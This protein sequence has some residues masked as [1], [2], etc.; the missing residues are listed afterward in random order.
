[1]WTAQ[2]VNGAYA[3]ADMKFVVLPAPNATNAGLH[4]MVAEGNHAFNL[5]AAQY[6]IPNTQECEHKTGWQTITPTMDKCFKLVF[7]QNAWQTLFYIDS[8]AHDAVAFFAQH[9]P[10]EFEATAHYLKDNV[11]TDVEPMAELPVPAPAAPAPTPAPTTE[12]DKPWGA[13]ILSAVLVNLVTL[14]GVI[15]VIPCSKRLL[16]TYFDQFIGIVSGFA[17]GAILACAFFLLLFEATHLIA[18]YWT[19]PEYEEVDVTW[20]WGTMILAGFVLPGFVDAG[21]SLVVRKKPAAAPPASGEGDNAENAEKGEKAELASTNSKARVIAGVLI[22]DFFHNLCDGFFLGAGFKG[23]GNSFGWGIALSTILHELPQE[24]ADYTILTGPLGGMGPIMALT[25]NFLSG[26]SV[27]IGAIMIVATDVSD[28]VTG[29]LLA[30]GGGVYIHIAATEC[31]PRIYN[32]KLSVPVRVACIASF[33]LG[34]VLIG[35]IL[36]DHE[37]C[38][39][40]A[41]PAAPGAAPAPSG[42]HH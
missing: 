34:C 12:K 14:I 4:H 2:K 10:T 41:P 1:M 20:R 31:M 38:V 35:L 25:T 37:H 32:E 5:A 42:H 28:H 6:F 11:G 29:L 17:A 26:L 21:A 3:D 9:V 15:L 8:T 39:P 27:L 23:C 33:I 7:A 36:L 13:T 19:A 22:G 18:T 40:P 30:F 24:L 16:E